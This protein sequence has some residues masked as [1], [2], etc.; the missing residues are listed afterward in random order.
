[1]RSGSEIWIK[2]DTANNAGDAGRRFS[3][4]QFHCPKQNASH[5]ARGPQSLI[6]PALQSGVRRLVFYVPTVFRSFA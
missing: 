6:A 2:K 3:E 5:Y 1:M 4:I